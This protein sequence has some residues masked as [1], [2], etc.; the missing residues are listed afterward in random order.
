MARLQKKRD[1]PAHLRSQTQE[2]ED[3][4]SHPIAALERKGWLM[5]A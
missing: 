2:E 1:D 4:H 5:I 3:N